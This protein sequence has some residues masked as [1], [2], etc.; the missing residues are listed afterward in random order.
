M[1]STRGRANLLRA[2]V[3]DGFTTQEMAMRAVKE[4]LD[5]CL[6]CKGCKAECPSAVDMAKLKY[7]FFQY[8]YTVHGHKR[9]LR[10]YLFG[11]ISE[12]LRIGQHLAPIVNLLVTNTMLGGIREKLLGLSHNRKLP[13]L[14]GRTIHDY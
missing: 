7:E 4:T 1:F 2:M 10:D 6:A 5:N 3:S 14:S 13:K 11:Y 8:Y 12:L 9:P